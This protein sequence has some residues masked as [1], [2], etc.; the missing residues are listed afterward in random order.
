MASMRGGRE[1]ERSRTTTGIGG[2]M[3]VGKVPGDHRLCEA[4]VLDPW[5]L[6]S[7]PEGR[8]GV[9]G[10]HDVVDGAQRDGRA[11]L[12]AHE[13]DV[14]HVGG[15]VAAVGGQRRHQVAAAMKPDAWS[16]AVVVRTTSGVLSREVSA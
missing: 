10:L 3:L 12:F 4:A 13:A 8:S 5:C 6:I 16:D 1:E 7:S 14:R 11:A 9:D 15:A 2:E